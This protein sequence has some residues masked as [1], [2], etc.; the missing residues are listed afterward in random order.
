MVFAQYRAIDR[1]TNE[2]LPI[3]R[4]R[5]GQLTLREFEIG[6][7]ERLI[8]LASAIVD[9]RVLLHGCIIPGLGYDGLTRAAAKF[10]SRN[11]TGRK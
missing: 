7:S 11:H 4:L 9:E 8:L 3:S 10:F 5:L 2:T 6:L 1:R